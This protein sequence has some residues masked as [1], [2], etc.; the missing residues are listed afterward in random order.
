MTRVSGIVTQFQTYGEPLEQ[1][2]I[3]EKILRCLTKKL[4]M[5][6]TAIE[7]ETYMPKFTLEELTR[8]LLSHEARFNHEEGSLTNSFSTQASLNRG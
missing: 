2:I 8:S 1:K 4:A 7:E 5:V 6:V 3:V